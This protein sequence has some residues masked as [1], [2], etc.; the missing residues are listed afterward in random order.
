MQNQQ[1]QSIP[2]WHERAK[3]VCGLV[4]GFSSESRRRR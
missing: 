1:G 4:T 2:G 3:L